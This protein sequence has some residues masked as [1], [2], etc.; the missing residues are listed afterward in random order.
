[1]V[2]NM[3]KE[4]LLNYVA[5]CSLL[6]CTCM[7]CKE[8]FL[9]D[10]AKRLKN[11]CE[12]VCE[13][14]CQ[15]QSE[16]QQKETKAFFQNFDGALWN[17]SGGSCNGC[18]NSDHS[19]GTGCIGGCPIPE[20]VK[21]HGIDFCAECNEFPC[22]TVKDFFASGNKTLIKVWENGNTRIKEIGAE[23]YFN[24]KKNISHYIHYKNKETDD[25]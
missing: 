23:A 5:P 11:Y 19:Y 9:T 18:R 14:F 22:Q 24:E 16:E 10:C 2:I 6:C 12:G 13:F 7:A 25:D 3:E 15:N 4:K 1:M 8:G 21:K 20:C 17:L